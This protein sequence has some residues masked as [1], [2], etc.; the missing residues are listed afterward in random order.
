MGAIVIYHHMQREGLLPQGHN[1]TVQRIESW[2]TRIAKMASKDDFE[3][4]I[5]AYETIGD[6]EIKAG[7]P[8]C[9][10]QRVPLTQDFIDDLN[11]VLKNRP[12]FSRNTF[13]KRSDAPKGFSATKF[14]A[15]LTGRVKTIAVTPAKWRLTTG[16]RSELLL[17]PRLAERSATHCIVSGCA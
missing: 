8:R 5:K 6:E 3:A 14:S 2:F 16:S 13:L 15:I 1:I 4:V 9:S 11:A 12:N 7:N 10:E 17:G